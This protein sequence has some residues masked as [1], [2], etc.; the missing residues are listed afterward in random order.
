[1]DA[2][3]ARK[4]TSASG[5]A[6]AIPRRAAST[7]GDQSPTRHGRTQRGARRH[8]RSRWRQDR[9]RVRTSRK[10]EQR[11][12]DRRSAPRR[13]L[14]RPRALAGWTHQHPHAISWRRAHHP[15]GEPLEALSALSAAAHRSLLGPIFWRRAKQLRRRDVRVEDRAS[16]DCKRSTPCGNSSP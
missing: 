12:R 4:R 14:A 16:D 6:T 3:T 9:H 10:T 2:I 7:T 5:T 13:S 1:M 8:E 11:R 15:Q